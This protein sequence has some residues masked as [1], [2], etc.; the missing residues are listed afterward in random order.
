MTQP[1]NPRLNKLF[2]LEFPQPVGAFA[3]YDEA[4][5]AVDFLA[6]A[7]F[8]VENLCIVGTDLRSMERVLGRRNWATV[9]G[10]GVQSGLSTGLLVG[11]LMMLFYQ[12]QNILAL[13]ATALVIGVLIGIIFAA[14]GYW[15]SQGKRDFTSVSQTIATRYEL[16]SEHKVAAQARELLNNL[17]SV[18]QASFQPQ[19]QP[20]PQAYG[21]PQQPPFGQQGG[22]P[23]PQQAPQPG[24]GGYPQQ[25]GYP[26]PAIGGYPGA[27]PQP[28]YGPTGPVAGP[29]QSGAQQ[30]WTPQQ[31]PS[32]PEQPSGPEPISP[33]AAE[34]ESTPKDQ[35]TD[36]Q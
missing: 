27:V 24:A 8:P 36:P 11:L 13:F 18:R 25:T 4:Q 23:Q 5:K 22:Y 26:Y 15:M 17:P 14:L 31:T 7:K 20:V 34:G 28:G 35:P 32:A 2:N 16:L 9:I 30:G 6:D 12:D 1:T 3:T 29:D 21:Y 19:Q 33:P 10:S